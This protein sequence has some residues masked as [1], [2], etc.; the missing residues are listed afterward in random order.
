CLAATVPLEDAGRCKFAELVAHHILGHVQ[1][2][3]YPA[4]VNQERVT[5][6]LW[7][8][9][10]I[11]R[12]RLERFTAARAVLT[13]HLGQQLLID[14]RAFFQRPAHGFP[15]FPFS[16]LVSGKLILYLKRPSWPGESRYLGA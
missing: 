15:L 10:A 2:H 14:I 1:P 5:H 12:P 11:A 13:L 16:A 8:N 3:E 6:E 9:R 7:H 4:I